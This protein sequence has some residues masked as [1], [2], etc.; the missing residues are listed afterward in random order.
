VPILLATGYGASVLPER[1]RVLPRCQKPFDPLD[2]MRSWAVVKS[3]RSGPNPAELVGNKLLAMLSPD[4]LA[5][6]APYMSLV[7]LPR[8]SLLDVGKSVF[9]T[10]GVAS[11]RIVNSSRENVEIGLVGREGVIG[12]QDGAS[13]SSGRVRFTM[14]TDGTGARIDTGALQR[15]AC[16]D[17][18]V[19]QLLQ[20]HGKNFLDQ[21]AANLLASSRYLVPQRI[22][23][24]ILL[25]T[26]RL[27]GNEIEVSHEDIAFALGMRRAGVTIAL[28]TLGDAGAV[29]NSRRH[30]EVVD[31][32]AL[33]HAAAGCYP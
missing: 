14:L 7:D 31:R 32:A 10:S 16:A 15:F 12:L 27:E 33:V 30:I 25:M 20:E 26:D 29:R 18:K 4:I 8:R 28:S 24:W 5:Q 22:A 11:C 23:R 2:L 13:R 19:Q 6:M 9:L 21:I 17:R 3:G 1:Y